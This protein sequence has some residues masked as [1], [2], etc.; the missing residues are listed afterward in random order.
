MALGNQKQVEAFADKL[1]ESADAIHER[2]MT[3]IK[4]NE[5]DRPHAQAVLQDEMLLRQRAN[6]LYIDAAEYVVEGLAESQKSLID[7]IDTA[8]A[9]IRTFKKVA[10]AIDVLADLLVLVA[11]VYATEP[12]PIVAALIE[13]RK[14]IN[15][16]KRL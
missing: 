7:A 16:Q 6:S 15:E 1:T 14:D 4:K 12:G 9:R 8:Q 5:I 13:I 2:L 11:A 3:A 10:R